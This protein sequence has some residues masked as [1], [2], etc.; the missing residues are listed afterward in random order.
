[1]VD[2]L[3]KLGLVAAAMVFLSIFGTAV[4]NLIPWSYL[5]QAFRVGRSVLNPIDMIWDVSAVLIVVTSMFSVEIAKW[6]LRA[7]HWVIKI[8]NR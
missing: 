4:N 6:S 3:K 5:I 7:V 1:M 2:L 8:L